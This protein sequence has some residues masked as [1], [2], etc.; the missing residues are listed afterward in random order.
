MKTFKFH[1]LL[2]IVLS[3]IVS[4]SRKDE[5]QGYN[6][7]GGAGRANCFEDMGNFYMTG[8]FVDKIDIGDKSGC[9][10]PPLAL[11]RDRIVVTTVNGTLAMIAGKKVEWTVKLDSGSIVTAGMAGDKNQNVYLVT[12]DGIL[13]SY[14]IEGKLRWKFHHD[15]L[16]SKGKIFSDLL[17]VND[18]V[19]IAASPGV[20]IKVGMDSKMHWEYFFGLQTLKTFCT[21]KSGNISIVATHNLFGKADTLIH[22]NPKGKI[23]WKKG[24]ELSRILR[25]A[26]SSGKLIVFPA[27]YDLYQDKLYKMI[28]LDTTGKIVWEKE[29]AVTPRYISAG[30]DGKIYLVAYNSGMG[31]SISGVYSYDS[32]GKMLWKQYL[33]NRIMSPAL[34]SRDNIGLFGVKRNTMGVFFLDKQGNLSKTVS[35]SQAPVF[36]QTPF[37]MPSP[38]IAFAG[39]DEFFILRIDDNAIDKIL[40]W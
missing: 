21:D 14:S 9:M 24:F 25:G 30:N 26:I 10:I 38:M 39:S 18:G 19:L 11:D 23:L 8:F 33:D 1:I 29:L 17:A 34:I 16:K 40:P 27:S 13:C 35:L 2:L 6:S 22:V 15:S 20:L 3:I 12:S 32:T 36:N 7:Q 31:E 4:C 37:V 28:A 5:I